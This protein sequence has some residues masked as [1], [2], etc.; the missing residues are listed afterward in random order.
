MFEL[1]GSSQHLS[2]T[3]WRATLNM[4]TSVHAGGAARRNSPSHGPGAN[5]SRAI[6]NTSFAPANSR[7]G[8]SGELTDNPELTH[9][10]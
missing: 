4:T 8:R 10:L 9:L 2:M 3:F 5:P 6:P 1:T 7:D